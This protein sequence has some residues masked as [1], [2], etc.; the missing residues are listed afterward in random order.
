MGPGHPVVK[1]ENATRRV[2]TAYLAARDA[3][4]GEVMALHAAMRAYLAAL[5]STPP[6]EARQRAV[7]LVTAARAK[8]PDWYWR[9]LA[10]PEPVAEA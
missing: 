10:V 2:M 9:N 8:A 7:Q 3:G 6:L 1:N 4:G 5:P